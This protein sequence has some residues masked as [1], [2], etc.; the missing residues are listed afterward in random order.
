M[1]QLILILS[2]IVISIACSVPEK[3]PPN[4]VLI[5]TDD[6]GYGD[7]S[8]FGSETI[9]TPNIDALADN[10][11]KFTDFHVS[12][13]TCTP[14]RAS[15]LTGCYPDRVGLPN[16]LFP[17]GAW[18]SNPNIGLNPEEETIAELL[19]QKGYATAMAGKWHLGH[20]EIFLPL[21]QGFDQYFGIPYSNDMNR[22]SL[23]LVMGNETVEIEPDQSLL[24]RRYTEFCIDFIN[25]KANK[26]PFFVYLAHTM[27]H[28]PIY[29]SKQL[30]GK[31]KGGLYGDV[32]EEI[33]WSVGKVVEALKENGVLENTLV[34]FTSDNGPWLSYGNHGGSSGGLRGGKFDVFE[35][36]FR[37]PAVM[38]WPDVMPKGMESDE[39]VSTLDI[40]PTLCQ[41]AG[42]N[43]PMNK[44]DG[45][46][47]LPLLRGEELTGMEDRFFYYF[48]NK[49]IKA[50]RKGKWKYIVSHSG[51]IVTEPGKDGINGKSEGTEHPQAL[52]DLDN[53]L[54]ESKNVMHVYPE[55][56]EDLK[57]AAENFSNSIIEE[58]RTAGVYEVSKNE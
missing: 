17:D 16:V 43:H 28:I 12:S 35:G 25:H 5:F 26:S 13:A 34:I 1:K 56:V 52:Y 18:G 55:I 21:Q 10:G 4:I 54:A 53:D 37:V 40:L 46:S 23:A 7:L 14:S 48:N 11:I 32:I 42:V 38:S 9:N 44:I 30:L 24:T 33:D 31:S 57:Q 36:G 51:G 27:P 47:I 8:C 19:K 15:L 49:E 6:Q 20:R 3:A 58:A 45:Q 2:C 22:G 41:I 29:A 39:L 50:V